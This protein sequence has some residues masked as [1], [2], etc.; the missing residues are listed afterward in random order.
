MLPKIDHAAEIQF[1][2]ALTG[3]APRDKFTPETRVNKSTANG[4]ST[5]PELNIESKAETSINVR[6]EAV[7]KT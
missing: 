2:V 1:T 4:K 5:S 3:E 6:F 7:A